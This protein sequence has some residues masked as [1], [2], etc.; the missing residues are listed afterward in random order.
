M[1]SSRLL[2]TLLYLQTRQRASATELA[3]HLG[4][5]VRTVYRDVEALTAAGVPIYADRGPSGGYRLL[6]GYRTRLTGLTGDEAS[7]LLFTG[8]PYAAHQLGIA[9]FLAAAELKVFAALPPELRA[10]VQRAR[11]RI[12]LDAPG[13]TTDADQPPQL[14]AVTAAVWRQESIIVTYRSWGGVK[15]RSLDPLGVVCKAGT[16]YLVA[17]R[18][19]KPAGPART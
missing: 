14:Q 13:W 12:H 3:D 1:K 18:T 7:A 4:V 10:R 8:L 2:M 5:S 6:D 15:T 16:W 19:D 11:E 17:L 9:S